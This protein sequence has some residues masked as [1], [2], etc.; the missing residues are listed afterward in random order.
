MKTIAPTPRWQVLACGMLLGA[1]AAAPAFAVHDGGTPLFELDGNAIENGIADD[2]ETIF[3]DGGN[4]IE[5]VTIFD[6]VAAFAADDVFVQG[7]SKDERDISAAGITNQYWR[8]GAGSS[9]D[10]ND[11]VHAFAAAYRTGVN[12]DGDLIIYFGLSR[13]AN[14]GDAAVGFWFFK[15]D[16]TKGAAP[17]FNGVHAVG[18]ILVTADFKRGGSASVINVFKWIGNQAG[19]PLQLLASSASSGGFVD[20]NTGVFCIA[21]DLAC[22]TAN[23]GNTPVPD[24]MKP[25]YYKSSGV[26]ESDVFPQG[27]LFEGGVN[28]TRL[29]GDPEICFSSFLGMTRTS[30]STTAQLKDFAIGD[31]NLCGLEVTKV[32]ENPRLN[33]AQDK[34]I[35][36]IRGTVTAIGGTVSG[37]ALS[38]NPPAD[39]AFE[40]YD[41]DTDASMGNFPLAS[42]NGTAC[43]RNTI[44]VDLIDN[45]ASDTVTATADAFGAALTAQDTAI[46]PQ[47]QINPD[48]SVTKACETV[49]T[50]SGGKVV[51]KVNVSGQ[52]CNTGDTNLYD[53]EV[54]DVG[55]STDPDPLLQVPLLAPAACEDYSGSYFPGAALDEHGN[56]TSDPTQVLFRDTVEASATTILGSDI[57]SDPAHAS[58]PLCDCPDC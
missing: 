32:C 37:V 17:N 9:P 45:G 33:A 18:D 54:I 57:T 31:F 15:N 49:V 48:I 19:G 1:F 58:C 28:F 14:D 42:L 35:Y 4:A 47:L 27:T 6:T 12:A 44:T 13:L 7:G 39:G 26:F 43:W 29:L 50:V 30:A 56:P 23:S 38:D 40:R 25:Y 10:K 3:H 53:V 5:T 8:H 21:G 24:S 55:I 41:C 36:D 16:V 11:I 34:I 2:W 51:A 46:C 20:P 52:V 22:A